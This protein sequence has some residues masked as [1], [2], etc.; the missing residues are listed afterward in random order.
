MRYTYDEDE[1]DTSDAGSGRLAGRQQ[2]AR[3]NSVEAGPTITAS[4]RQIRKPRTGDY[5]EGL[6]SGNVHDVNGDVDERNVDADSNS[7]A[8][9]SGRSATNGEHYANGRGYQDIDD[10]ASADEWDSDKN[11]GDDERMP[12]ADDDKEFQADAEDDD[13]DEEEEEEEEDELANDEEGQ[14]EELSSLV[15]KLRIPGSGTVTTD[16]TPPTSPHVPS[17]APACPPQADSTKRLEADEVI[18]SETLASNA[19]SAAEV[20]KQVVTTGL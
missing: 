9:R 19:D 2:S 5:G 8:R 3:S 4:G 14:P 16:E 6:L 13:D 17:E 7:R 18:P 12:D 1:D 15:V 10:A 20:Q 11:D